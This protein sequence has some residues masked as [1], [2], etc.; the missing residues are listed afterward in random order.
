MQTQ[1]RFQNPDREVCAGNSHRGDPA[2]GV[3]ATFHGKVW[4]T[5]GTAGLGVR[6]QLLFSRSVPLASD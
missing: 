5:A 2:P 3:S 6:I 1:M 4:G